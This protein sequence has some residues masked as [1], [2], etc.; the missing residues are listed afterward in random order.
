MFNFTIPRVEKVDRAR[1]E[2]LIVFLTKLTRKITQCWSWRNVV[3]CTATPYYAV[4]AGGDCHWPR[5]IVLCLRRNC[6]SPHTRDTLVTM[7]WVK[8]Y[9]WKRDHA[10]IIATDHLRSFACSPSYS[11]CKQRKMAKH[12][13]RTSHFM[14][15]A[16]NHDECDTPWT[17]ISASSRGITDT[18][19]WLLGI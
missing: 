1:A 13:R 3:A 15:R 16:Q 7:S 10:R 4:W 12:T 11:R 8:N 5:V 14:S 17:R 18:E 19:G 9:E 2:R 6:N